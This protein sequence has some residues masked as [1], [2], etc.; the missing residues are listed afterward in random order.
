VTDFSLVL[1]LLLYFCSL[2]IP[3]I[4]LTIS[5]SR[6]VSEILR[7]IGRKS[8]NFHAPLVFEAPVKGVVTLSKFCTKIK[9]QNDTDG[10]N[11]ST[12]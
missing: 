6:T 9:S 3:Y 7:L 8:R 1:L 10:V 2:R 11:C 12:I 5:L 4:G